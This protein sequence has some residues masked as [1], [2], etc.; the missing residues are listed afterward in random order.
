MDEQEILKDVVV[1]TTKAVAKDVYVDTLK[2]TAQ[3]VGGF[4]GTLSGFFNHVVV[5]PLKKLN[6]KYQQK[7]I[8]FERQMAQQY[9]NIPDDCRVEPQ[10]HIVGPAM[11]SL[12]YRIMEDDIA[13]LYSN[14]LLSNMDSRTQ[15]I[16]NPTF[17]KI[18]EQ[19]SPIDAKV[20][21]TLSIKT[22]EKNP[23]KPWLQGVYIATVK[24]FPAFNSLHD[25]IKLPTYMLSEIN[26]PIDKF[27]LSK[28]IINLERLGLISFSFTDILAEKTKQLAQEIENPRTT[29]SRAHGRVR[30]SNT[31]ESIGRNCIFEANQTDGTYHF[32]LDQVG[33][34]TLNDFAQSFAQVCF[35]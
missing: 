15:G 1:E 5:Y 17:V 30:L 29:I 20:F 16:C 14:L 7:A 31:N 25:E 9:G 22:R 19:L 13:K 6:I 10:L 2:P 26:L 27:E 11:D 8:A 33:V 32:D 12:K 18:I 21:Q 24:D 34:I 3:N 4:F 23:E 28:S 35:R